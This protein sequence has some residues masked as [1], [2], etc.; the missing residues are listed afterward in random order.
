[1]YVYVCVC[2]CVVHV[3]V[4]YMGYVRMYVFGGMCTVEVGWQREPHERGSEY[5]FLFRRQKL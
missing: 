2:V 5:E 4:M 1:M 3:C